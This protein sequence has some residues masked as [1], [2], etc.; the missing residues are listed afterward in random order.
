MRSVPGR[1]RSLVL[2][3]VNDDTTLTITDSSQGDPYRRTLHLR[4][5]RGAR[6]SYATYEH[7]ASVELDEDEERR[8]RE[9]LNARAG[10]W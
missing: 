4:F 6:D 2:K 3:D 1:D 8:L 9:L 5:E 10:R 7:L